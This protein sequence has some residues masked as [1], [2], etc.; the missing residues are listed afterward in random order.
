MKPFDQQIGASPRA[1]EQVKVA[2]C[3][4]TS[5]ACELLRSALSRVRSFQVVACI[6]DSRYIGQALNDHPDV[7]L[8]S[9]RLAD[10]PVAGFRALRSVRELS[11][12][13]A[14]V[15]LLDEWTPELVV[16]AFR[17]GAR[18][19]FHRADNFQRLCRC[20]TVVK[21]GQI[22]AGTNALKIV[23]NAFER[24][25]PLRIVDARGTDLLTNREQQV[26]SLV[27]D[28]LN[29]REIS[30]Q[31]HLSE[32]TVKNHLFHI[33]EKLGISSRVELVLYAIS[34]RDRHVA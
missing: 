17:G 16:D 5:I 34:Q 28:G 3:E 4:S 6:T 29:N 9:S 15:V 33:F 18:G 10:G 8:I 22:W 27:V 11:P 13:T 25:A 7:M 2:V 21:E 14:C 19:V 20:L 23:L 1:G 30:E 24:F 31:L 32:H 12:S 26:V